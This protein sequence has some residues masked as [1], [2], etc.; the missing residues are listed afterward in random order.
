MAAIGGLS[1]MLAI[2]AAA[3][4]EITISVFFDTVKNDHLEGHTYGV[5]PTWV[6]APGASCGQVDPAGDIATFTDSMACTANHGCAASDFTATID[7]G[8]PLTS[9]PGIVSETSPG[10][11]TVTASHAFVDEFNP[12]TNPTCA[13]L[14]CSYHVHVKVTDNVD[15]AT[16]RVDDSAGGGI[17]V[18]D[19]GFAGGPTP[20]FFGATAGRLFTGAIGSFQDGNSKASPSDTTGG[21]NEYDVKILYWGDGTINDFSNLPVTVQTCSLTPGTAVGEGCIVAIN[22]SHTYQAVGTY[23]VCGTYQDG[24]NFTAKQSFCS[25]GYVTAA[26]IAVK[27]APASSPGG[28]SPVAQSP[29]GAPGPRIAAG[30]SSSHTRVATRQT[31]DASSAQSHG[32]VSTTVTTTHG[33]ALRSFGWFDGKAL[34]QAGTLPYGSSTSALATFFKAAASLI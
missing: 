10:S 9:N 1:V 30:L 6:C 23:N 25:T 19:E 22:G 2:N 15:G 21:T 31:T 34:D 24:A 32:L 8:D 16:N 5:S 7:W 27:P 13:N 11:Y 28:R 33:I 26:R 17:A 18:G 3:S 12:A 4:S 29:A 20:N 14:P